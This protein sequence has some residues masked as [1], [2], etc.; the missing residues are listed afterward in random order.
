M[1]PARTLLVLTPSADA[2]AGIGALA[3]E[4]RPAIPWNTLH[5]PAIGDGLAAA[6][7]RAD[8]VVAL[9]GFAEDATPV[10]PAKLLRPAAALPP[11]ALYRPLP[12]APSRR[13][14]RILVVA[15]ERLAERGVALARTLA[16]GAATTL[17][18]PTAALFLALPD[19]DGVAVRA[20]AGEAAWLD[21]LAQHDLVVTADAEVATLANALLKPAVL[22]GGPST[23]PFVFAAAADG[24]AD[25]VARWRPADSMPDLVNWKRAGQADWVA[26]LDRALA[27]LGL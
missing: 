20:V 5:V 24:V 21:L 22:V 26:A 8:L 2:A 18:A 19:L 6:A 12:E 4:A 27:A 13:L 14:E 16:H 1:E 9:D 11:P 7:A 23:A 15:D 10:P 3:A 17:G 25:V